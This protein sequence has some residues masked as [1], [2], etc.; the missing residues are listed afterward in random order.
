MLRMLYREGTKRSTR[1][2]LVIA[3]GNSRPTRR[4]TSGSGARFTRVHSGPTFRQEIKPCVFARL[5]ESRERKEA[6]RHDGTAASKRSTR[7]RSSAR[8]C[9]GKKGC[10]D[11][12]LR[13]D[14]LAPNTDFCTVHSA[15]RST[16]RPEF[17]R[18]IPDRLRQIG[19][20]LFTPASVVA[21][22]DAN[23]YHCERA[24]HGD[25]IVARFTTWATAEP[26]ERGASI[27]YWPAAH[28]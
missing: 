13:H 25:K 18:T 28:P 19:A 10:G 24:L 23:K 26:F 12:V 1:T 3:S 2:S 27:T 22:F 15:C 14:R 16:R 5:R 17:H 9:D 7:V 21:G 4:W 11:L 8:A 20:G 6:W